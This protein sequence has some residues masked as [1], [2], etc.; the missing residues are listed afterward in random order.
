MPVFELVSALNQLSSPTV[1]WP[2][3]VLHESS[4]I[5]RT[6]LSIIFSIQC[7][8]FFSF[9]LSILHFFIFHPTHPVSIIQHPVSA[10]L[11]QQHLHHHLLIPVAS[12]NADAGGV[13]VIG[14]KDKELCGGGCVIGAMFFGD[15]EKSQI[16]LFI[17]IA[18]GNGRANRC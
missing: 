5:K 7:N 17:E 15:S 13:S 4:R 16:L 8:L 3:T 12:R 11:L 9:I 6:L 14:K 10:S 18:G 1:I 2:W